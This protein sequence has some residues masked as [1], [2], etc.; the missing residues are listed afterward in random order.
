MSEIKL[1]FTKDEVYADFEDAHVSYE[2]K[3]QQDWLTLHNEFLTARQTIARLM[4]DAEE[5]ATIVKAV[6][7][8]NNEVGIGGEFSNK[9]MSHALDVHNALVH[10]VERRRRV[11]PYRWS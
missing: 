2:Q 11:F 8:T 4:E 10:E 9:L 1:N 7:E 5:L 6:Q 3:L